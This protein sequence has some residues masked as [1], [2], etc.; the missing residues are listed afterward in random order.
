MDVGIDDLHAYGCEAALDIRLLFEHRGLDTRRFENLM[1]LAKSVGMPFEDPVTHA[2]NAAWPIVSALPAEQRECIELLITASESGLDFGKSLSTYIHDQ[3]RLSRRCRVIEIK[4][5]CY[6]ATAALQLAASYVRSHAHAGYAPKVLIIATDVARSAAKHTYAE[7]S[8][9]AAAVAMLV[10]RDPAVLNLDFGASGFHSFEV[11]DTCRP[12]PEIE[13]G[14]PD[15]SLLTYLECLDACY[16]NYCTVVPDADV[17]GTFDHLLFHAPFPG[18]VRGAHRQLLRKFASRDAALAADAD[19]QR[20]VAPSLEHVRQV[21]NVYSASVYLG[22]LSLLE[23][24]PIEREERVGL[25]SYGSGCSAEW[26]SGV[27]NPRGAQLVRSRPLRPVLESRYRLD[28]EEYDRLLDANA[29][30]TF[31]TRDFE[32]QLDGCEAVFE[33]QF[34]KRR[35]LMLRRVRDYHRE[36]VWSDEQV[37]V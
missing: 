24:A 32:V 34:R 33:Q 8:Q 28:M 12:T 10:A 29:R 5:A 21:G 16:R 27:V 20:R 19:F 1:M 22:L 37:F 9:G 17:M 23:L 30:L 7:P 6:A 4:Q 18:M 35:R 26:F 11:M 14:D 3:L 15:L 13:S 36:Y 25:F 2:V 31:G